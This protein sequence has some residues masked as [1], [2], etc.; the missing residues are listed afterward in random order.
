M[1]MTKNL[2]KRHVFPLLVKTY[3]FTGGGKGVPYFALSNTASL[4]IK[5]ALP[6]PHNPKF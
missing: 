3:M 4:L 6:P 5:L 1:M 2:S